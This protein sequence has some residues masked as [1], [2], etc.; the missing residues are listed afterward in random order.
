[1]AFLSR[2]RIILFV[3][4]AL[5]IQL[6]VYFFLIRHED[7]ITPQGH[8]HTMHPL[9]LYYPA[10]IRQSKLGS[11]TITDP[12]TTL[13]TPAIHAYVFFILAGKIA[14][15][16]QIDPVM[17]YEFTRI[18]G[19]VFLIFSIYWSVTRLLPKSLHLLTL[20][21]ALFIDT[22]PAWA[23]ILSKPLAHWSAAMPGASI[24]SRSF[25]LPHHSV[26]QALGLILLCFI[27]RAIK[28]PTARL[29][30]VIGILAFTGTSFAPPF[31]VILLT[32]LFI[33]WLSFS[34]ITKTIKNT[35]PTIFF[36]SA[37]I[38]LA[39]LWI[40]FEF[41][42][43]PPWSDYVSVE[44]SW[45]PMREIFVQFIQSFSLYYPFIILL[46]I[47]APFTIK[48]WPKAMRR[49]LFLIGS[50]SLLPF[51]LIV[52]SAFPWFPIA[53]GRIASDVSQIPM[54]I[55]SAL[56]V[57][58]LWQTVKTFRYAKNILMTMLFLFLGF[59]FLLTTS[60]MK[61]TLED[62]IRFR[63]KED[64]GWIMYPTNKL[65]DGIMALRDVPSGSN[66]MVLPHVGQ[67]LPT[68]FPVHVYAGPPYSYVNWWKRRDMSHKF[69]TGKMSKD[70]VDRFLSE[71][72]ISY[73][74]YGPEEVM[75]TKT[76]LF[77]PDKLEIQYQ[78]PEVTIFKVQLRK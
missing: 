11:W 26:S 15:L 6:T 71:N 1:M 53:N 51:G 17:M 9:D 58:T 56:G 5:A 59:S 3:L 78:N 31:F 64:F 28:S 69:Y 75:A 65:W 21:F 25:A 43:G 54:S 35:L 30:P 61:R 10:I 52:L 46:F 62:H 23:D 47:F 39:G 74:F 72:N 42:K 24:I 48:V 27:V 49:I 70:E 12:Y 40:K 33:P 38:I 73:I 60:Y 50:W 8:V 36:A 16:F 19:G 55:L 13:P 29:Y 14:A 2:H 37:G 20:I 4:L 45:W 67:L 7:T 41:A 66:I 34:Y 68:Y 76:S 57:Y 18:F 44:K 63:D 77:Y 22:G 32:C